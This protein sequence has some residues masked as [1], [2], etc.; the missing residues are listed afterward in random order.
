M[1]LREVLALDIDIDPENP[2]DTAFKS[3][4]VELN[5]RY[6]LTDDDFYFILEK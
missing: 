2:Y 5:Y 4:G 1:Y 6:H 3:N